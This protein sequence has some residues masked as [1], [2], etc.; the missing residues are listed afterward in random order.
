MSV[1]RDRDHYEA[2]YA[3]KLW[4]LL[5]AVYRAEDSNSLDA[6]GP[7]R[8]LVE[9]IGAQAAV[10]RRSIDRLWEDQ[11]I[12]T[13][14]DWLIPYIADLLATNLVSAQ[15]PRAQRLDVAKTIYYRRRKGT[16]AILEEIAADV[17]GW[18]ARVV[19]FFRRLGR[20][21]H[22]LDPAIGWPEDTEDPDG[23][24][25]LQVAQGL[26][27]PLTK[28]QIGG[29]ADLRDAY[30]ASLAHSAF[31]EYF[32]TAD[33]RRGVGQVG[34]YN[35][36]RLGVFL[37]RLFSFELVQST[38]VPVTGC[39]GQYAF[40]P[41]GRQIP[42]FARNAREKAGFGHQWV[43]PEEWQMPTPIRKRLLADQLDQVS[44]PLV[45][46]DMDKLY[47]ASLSV[48]H[49]QGFFFDLVDDVSKLTLYPEIGRFLVD[50]TLLNDNL[51]IGYH[52]GFSSTIGAG[53][54]DR[55]VLRQPALPQPAPAS[56]VKD[57]TGLDAALAALGAAGTLTIEDSLTYV[58]T[59]DLGGIE[60]VTLRAEDRQR[61][62]VRLPEG[63]PGPTVWAFTGA[64]DD[65]VVIIDG[66]L[67]SGGNVALR[68]QFD[69]VVIN[70]CTFDPGSADADFK[71]EKSVDERDLLPTLLLI[72]GAVRE[73]V[74]DRSI[75][76]P[77]QENGG[78]V[79]K[80]IARD[81]I[82]QSHEDEPAISV[83]SGEVEL[84][85]CTLLG[86]AKLHRLEASECI[87][88][89]VVLV[90]DTQHGCV[91]FSAWATGSVIPRKYESVEIA[92]L[93]MLFTSRRFGQ[94]GYCQLLESAD[95]AIV[96]GGPGATIS[97]GAENGSE[98][99]AFAREKNPIKRRSLAIKYEEFMPLGLVPVFI[100]VT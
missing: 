86:K 81:S 33:L 4:N 5:P 41:T 31:D 40:D 3:D 61:P 83:V 26:V 13:S 90:D 17:T 43:S 92:P 53:P 30:G 84:D 14:D 100:P 93:A 89:D 72:E 96:S 88:N 56:S 71:F 75:M 19:E 51:R 22:N 28:S 66:L 62:V 45:E 54:Y 68:G 36:P 9:R 94:P 6:R 44:V 46:A 24:R 85:R 63:A 18:E 42:L 23:A 76:G 1:D 78:R 11:S 73:L 29:T 55:R 47:P 77:V 50:N 57:G 74:I 52:Y 97:Q 16:V 59:S 10:L 70:C 60:N 27:G 35:I 32:H 21:R 20:S 95:Q 80:L 15:D 67:V 82:I 7:L 12:E 37:W 25:V 99:G 48:Y 2:Y 64:G 98:M 87:L 91:R 79:Q 65:S 8:E 58:E 49:E 69:R 38:P 39:D 34:W